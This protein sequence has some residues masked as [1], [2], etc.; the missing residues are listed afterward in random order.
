M[1]YYLRLIRLFIGT[2]FQRE[3]AFRANFAISLLNT[4]LTLI[5]GLA[6]V[7]ILFG[8]VKTIQGWTFPQA[9]TLVGVYLLV[10]ALR[11]ICIGPSLETLGGL[12]GEIFVGG[13]DFTLLKPVP[14][15]FLVSVRNWRLWALG[16]L[17]LSLVVMGVALARLG[18]A[19]TLP[20]LA[21]FLVALL[22]SMTIVYSVLLLLASCVFW[23]RGVPLTW[24]FDSL[25]Q[26]GRYP[27]G[28]YPGWLRLLLT[29][30]VP[31]GFITSVPAQA[32]TG[33]VPAL[34]L[35]GGAALALGLLALASAFLRLSLR[36]YS[37][38]S[39]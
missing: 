36:R 19:L 25:I 33:Q 39:S 21:L 13:F 18:Q 20:G 7:T 27:V 16:D 17:T 29:W 22:V 15:Q 37:S 9:L 31:V 30:V 10:G 32:L 1:G 4:A 23:Y 26:M 11:D 3:T 28:I 2:S 6:G 5:A 12:G 34:T 38:A 24:I 14:T 35:V 8:Q